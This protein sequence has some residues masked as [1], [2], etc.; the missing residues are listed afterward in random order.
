MPQNQ[1]RKIKVQKHIHD[2]PRV[3]YLEYVA[4]ADGLIR[5]YNIHTY[6]VHYTLQLYKKRFLE[7]DTCQGKYVNVKRDLDT[8]TRLANK[9]NHVKKLI[10]DRITMLGRKTAPLPLLA[11]VHKAQSLGQ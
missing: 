2:P 9:I 10:K 6:V 3:G 8:I 5:A 7:N 1:N 11:C 4:Y